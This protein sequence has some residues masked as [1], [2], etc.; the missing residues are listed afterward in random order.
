MGMDD[1]PNLGGTI[2]TEI[3]ISPPNLVSFSAS[4]CGLTGTIPTEIGDMTDLIQIWLSDN[5]LTGTIPSELGRIPSAKIVNFQGNFLG[6][7]MPEEICQRRRP[8]GRLEE[9]GADCSH[10][11][12]K[13]SSTTMISCPEECCTCCGIENC[14]NA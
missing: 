3:G 13:E 6:G 7:D 4:N 5:Q 11:E 14:L 12:V 2:P 10:S 8:F 1:N 9:L